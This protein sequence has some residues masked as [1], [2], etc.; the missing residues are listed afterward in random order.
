MAIVLHQREMMWLRFLSPKN[1]KR[2]IAER[3]KDDSAL[4][5]AVS[6]FAVPRSIRRQLAHQGLGRKPEAMWMRE[7]DTHLDA[8]AAWLGDRVWLVGEALTI[9]DLAVFA[10]LFCIAGTE[11]GAQA[12]AARPIVKAW[13]ARID[14][15]TASAQA[16][17]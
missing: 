12:L 9:A 17:A 5:R 8:I 7:L 1:R 15:A 16:A 6:S 4:V 3:V 13:I 11:E 14:A 10:Q 2:W